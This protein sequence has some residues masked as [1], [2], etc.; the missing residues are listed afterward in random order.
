VGEKYFEL[1][2]AYHWLSESQL[3]SALAYYALYPEE[4]DARLERNQDLNNEKIAKKNPDGL[5]AYTIEFVTK[6]QP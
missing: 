4:I 2:K 1:K 6:T 5:G 3:R